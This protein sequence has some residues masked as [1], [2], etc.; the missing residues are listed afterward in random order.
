MPQA[1]RPSEDPALLTILNIVDYLTH[2]NTEARAGLAAGDVTG[3]RATF[4]GADASITE[5][6]SLQRELMK[7]P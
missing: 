5:L 7:L 4:K 2:W 6:L 3:A 1:S